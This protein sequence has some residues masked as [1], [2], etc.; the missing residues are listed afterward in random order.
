MWLS[1][2]VHDMGTDWR[3]GAAFLKKHLIDYDPSSNYGTGLYNAGRG[4][5]PR[6]FRKFN[7]KMQAER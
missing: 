7:T 4:N 5:D 1:Y 6:P 2:L 3:A